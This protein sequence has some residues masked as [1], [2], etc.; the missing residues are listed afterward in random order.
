MTTTAR[1]GIVVPDEATA[2]DVPVHMLA[3]AQKLDPLVMTF[4]SSTWALRPAPAQVGRLL[5]VTDYA[6]AHP[7]SPFQYDTGAAWVD[8]VPKQ[9]L[10][11][12][13]YVPGAFV[14]GVRPARWIAPQSCALTFGKARMDGGTSDATLKW[15]LYVNG[16]QA[17][18][19][20]TGNLSGLVA[21]GAGVTS[22][23]FNPDLV[24]AEG[25]TVQL[26]VGQVSGITAADLSVTVG[27]H[28][29]GAEHS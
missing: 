17:V 28:W 14:A 18:T 7:Q 19:G 24:I 5:Y 20:G 9:Q 12:P 21:Q 13:F 10:A 27:G 25:D 1:L 29:T 22:Y 8:W 15:G 2:N 16:T 3:I 23:D 6:T 26:Y 4:T 11:I